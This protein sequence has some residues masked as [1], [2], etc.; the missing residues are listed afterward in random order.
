MGERTGYTSGT[1]CWI[2]LTAPDQEQ[3]KRFYSALFGWVAEDVPVAE[4]VFYSLQ[5]LDGRQVG[6]IS[7]QPAQQREA[8]VPPAWN[9]YV[10]VRKADAALARARE[11]GAAVHA[12]AFDVFDAGRM[13]VVQDPQGAYFCVWE[14]GNHPGAEL[15]NRP[16]ALTWNELYSPDLEAS[17]QFYA[18][19]FDWRIEAMKGSPMP[20]RMIETAA[21]TS[22]GGI[23][24]MEG[25]PPVWLVYFGT[26]D[27]QAS[28]GRAGKLGGQVRHGPVDIPWGKI[29]VLTDPGGATFALFEGRL[30]D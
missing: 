16:G 5:R 29:A 24:T 25:V 19:L 12:D 2:D 26:D 20:Y 3:A 28:C 30:D 1:F 9:S 18:N 11:L 15:V 17:S 23:T 4:G 14:A 8:G 21:G 22:N 10:A 7:P 27:I 13:G 6:A